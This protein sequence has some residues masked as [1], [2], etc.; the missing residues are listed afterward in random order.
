[1]PSKVLLFMFWLTAPVIG[2]MLAFYQAD[3]PFFP[4]EPSGLQLPV[5]PLTEGIQLVEEKIKQTQDLIV[6]IQLGAESEKKEFEQQNQQIAQL[7]E[8]SQTQLKKSEDVLDQILSNMLGKPIGQTFG[9]RATIKVFSLEEAGYKGFMAKVKLHDPQALKMVLGHDAVTSKGETTSQ[10]A[11][12]KQAVLAINAGGF[13]TDAQ[14]QLV[15]LG[16]TVVDGQVRTF[17][18][19]TSL[20]FVGFNQQGRLVGGNIATPEQ[21]QQMGILQGASFLPTLLQGGQKLPIPAEWARKKH[22]RTLIGHFSNGDLLFIV[23]DG[24][25]KGWS[26]GVTLEEAQN[27][28]LDFKVRDAYNLDGG[29]SSVFYYNGKVL[30][31]PSDGKERPVSTNI[32]ILP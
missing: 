8:N 11:R 24:R 21:L 4:A 25:R 19:S 13:R 3:Y 12:R 32:V 29:G 31:R 26:E 15:P 30:N 16:I 17:S 9:K 23:I 7:L 2:F 1:M 10:A 22:P 18:N 27:K 5:E 28:L 14:G 6:K 20:S